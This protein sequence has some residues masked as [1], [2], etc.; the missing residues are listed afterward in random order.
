MKKILS[1][2][3]LLVTT[4][5]AF[6]LDFTDYRKVTL[7]SYTPTESNDAKLSVTDNG[8]GTYNV[9]FN[10]IINKDGSYTDN[11]GTFTFSNVS[12]STSGD[13]T[14]VTATDVTGTVSGGDYRITEFT[15]GNLSLKFKDGKAY[16]TMTAT[17]RV[18]YS[19]YT[20]DVVFGTDEGFGGG[21]STGGGEVAAPFEKVN[22][23]GDG[24]KFKWNIPVD[25]ATQKIVMSISTATCTTGCEHIIGLGADATSWN[26]NLHMYRT[27]SD[28]LLQCYFDAG[29]GNNNTGKFPEGNPIKVEISKANGL[30][31]D[32]ETRIAASKLSDLFAMSTVVMGT[33]EGVNTP[34]H[35]TYNY[36]KVVPLDW[37]EVPPVTVDETFT[38]DQ[39]AFVGPNDTKGTANVKVYKMTDDSYTMEITAPVATKVGVITVSEDAKGRTTYMGEVESSVVDGVKYVV[40]GVVYEEGGAKHLYM[41]LTH[42]DDT[43]IIGEN[44]DAPKVVSTLPFENVAYTTSYNGQGTATVT[45]TEMSDG[46]FPMTFASDGLNVKAENLTKA[47]DAKGRT[48]YTGTAIRTDVDVTFTVKAVVY[49]EA[50]AQKLYMTMDNGAGFVVTVG[51]DPDYVAPV[52][53]KNTLKV[54]R[55]TDTKTYENAEVSVLAKGE[56]KYAVTIPS[57]T[58]MDQMEGT[59]G[60]LTFEATGVE[61]NGTLKL[62]ATSAA[63]TQEGGSGWDNAG[64]TAS[65]DATVTGETLAGTF[66]VVYPNDATNYTYTLYYGVEPPTTPEAPK[67]V[68]VVEKYQADGS[69]FSRTINV[70]WDKQKIVASIDFSNGGDDK[71]ILAMTTG[72]SFAAFQTSTYRT[73]H[74]YCNQ[75]AKQMSGFFAKDGA[76]NNNTGRMDVADCLAKFEISK[77]E[78]LKVNGEVK[79]TPTVLEELLTGAPIIIGSGESPKFSNAFYNY[80]KVVSLDWK[81]PTEPEVTVKDEKTFNEALYMQ[82]QKVAD[83]TVVV[84][85]MSDETI[86]MSL[87]FGENEYTSTELTKGTDTKGRT[88]YTGKVAN[89]TQT[90]D[91]AGVVYEK[92]NVARLYMTLKTSITT[93]VV[94][95]NP[96]AVTPEVTEVSNKTYTSNLRIFDGEEPVVENAEA[97]VNIIK[98]SDESY[99]VTLKNV[100][101]LNKTQDLVFVG[102]AL[103]E[104]APTEATEPLTIIAKSD[105]ATTTFFG[106]EMNG[107]FEITEVSA[108]EIKMG[109]S[110][111]SQNFS[112]QGE[113]NYTEEEEPEVYTNNLHIYDAAAPETDL[114]QADQA[115]VEFLATATGE[116]KLTLKDVTLNENT[117]DLV[118]TGM[119]SAPEPGG[120]DP[121]AEEGET[122]PA[123]P[124][125]V[126][127]ATADEAT[128]RFFGVATY[129]TA[130]F[131]V[132]YDK[133]DNFMMTFTITAGAK[134][135]GGEFNYEKKNPDTPDP[136]LFCKEN[137]VAD[138]TG[139]EWDINVDWDTQKIVM[140]IDPSTCTGS[141][142]DVIGL[143]AVPTAW[144][145][146]LHLYRTSADQML[147]GYFNVPGG[148]NNNT[149][150]FAETAPF[151]VEVSKAQGFVVNNEVKI[152]SSAM[153]YLFT[154]PTV[155]MGTGE[156]A[157][158]KSRATYNY[159]KVV[160]KDWT[161]PKDPDTGIN[162][163]TVA[164]GE[165][166]FFTVNG[167]KL[168]K[169]QKG[170]NIVRT[171]D[172]KVKKVL[173]K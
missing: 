156:G 125:M 162:A 25:W 46:T 122:T 147:Q 22:F 63:T 1:L 36:V 42:D 51:E 168:N 145:N 59:I 5:S 131:N 148:S 11:Y 130:V 80:I 27:S 73:M 105:E 87:K 65:M 58:D 8:D 169:L 92:D 118:F 165:V 13:V 88:T 66:T 83:A 123:E 166:E 75:T 44:P 82:D 72:D 76:G 121:L 100:N 62:T 140:S 7:G 142:E 151:L 69:G 109:F 158:D 6:A 37:T 3:V 84:K 14:T 161:A 115:K 95:E 150:K 89:G 19:N 135:Y 79:M 137:Y 97:Q 114:F 171:A 33:G 96:D 39:D 149:N 78:G 9:T 101:M 136:E 70:D 55:G 107:T 99:K 159:V 141:C 24:T 127:N 71:D 143:G 81:E 172:G 31:V 34:S 103:I 21:G 112:Y 155:K 120:Q 15:K 163:T 119:L 167:V 41:T 29:A 50:A 91:V 144:D 17:C 74:W 23:V 67:D 170:L 43:Y 60:K 106:E 4:L 18:Y 90:Y 173:V 30:I 108:D 154:L 128:T 164:E 146:T 104:E 102:K 45:F 54:V 16:A 26:N 160:D 111:E 57:F 117:Q 2:L 35:A 126:L 53:Y 138:G 12:G 48:T 86:N 157:N 40:N 49:G 98:Y 20:F 28:Q 133:N 94:G 32:G 77:A 129:P 124:A 52:T 116:F 134:N 139:F 132:S 10:D 68:T 56:N 61:E 113:F 152:A 110:M 93:V 64:F 47:T 85:E 153:S 38:Y